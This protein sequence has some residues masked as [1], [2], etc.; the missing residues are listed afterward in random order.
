MRNSK[1]DPI[2]ITEAL[3]RHKHYSNH[4]SNLQRAQSKVKIDEQSLVNLSADFQNHFK[5]SKKFKMEQVQKEQYKVHMRLIDRLLEIENGKQLSV[6][7]HIQQLPNIRKEKVEDKTVYQNFARSMNVRVRQ[8]RQKL[9]DKQNLSMID[10]IINPKTSEYVDFTKHQE[11]YRKQMKLKQRISRSNRNQMSMSIDQ[12]QL[13]VLRK[14]GSNESSRNQTMHLYSPKQKI[15]LK[16]G[17]QLNQ[18]SEAQLGRDQSHNFSTLQA[19]AEQPKEEMRTLQPSALNESSVENLAD[20]PLMQRSPNMDSKVSLKSNKSNQMASPNS[21]LE[22]S[23]K[24]YLQPNKLH[25]VGK[26][27]E[28]TR[29]RNREM[30]E[31]TEDLAEGVETKENFKQAEWDEDEPRP[32]VLPEIPKAKQPTESKIALY[33]SVDNKNKIS[34]DKAYIQAH[35]WRHNLYNV[36]RYRKVADPLPNNNNYPRYNLQKALGEFR[37]SEFLR[38]GYQSYRMKQIEKLYKPLTTK[39]SDFVSQFE[40]LDKKQ[41][42]P[43]NIQFGAQIVE[44][45]EEEGGDNDQGKAGAAVASP[46]NEK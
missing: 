31:V 36:P 7:K 1:F 32:T 14:K 17:L 44:K 24:I 8:S 10:K 39:H 23:K 28:T 3:I 25:K 18:S 16:S 11:F 21:A 35:S 5:Y 42:S 19:S 30:K 26:Q 45:H 43:P 38:D 41:N 29:N 22:V 2:P 15:H 9:I 34:L 37:Y 13:R 4:L 33:K 46:P 12:A 40:G 20:L 6:T 27:S